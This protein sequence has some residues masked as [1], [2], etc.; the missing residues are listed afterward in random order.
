MALTATASKSTREL[1]TRSLFMVNSISI[2]MPPQKKNILYCVKDKGSI[3]SLVKRICL[4]LKELLIQYLRTIIFCKCYDECSEMY[5]TFRSEIKDYSTYPPGTPNLA[6]YRIV[7]TY[8][9]CT[10]AAVKESILQSICMMDGKLCIVIA[11]IAFGMCLDC[12]DIREVIHWGPSS[13]IESYVQETGRVGRDS[14]LSHVTLF[15]ASAGPQMMSYVSKCRRQ[16][17]FSD[18]DEDSGYQAP[19]ELCQCCDICRLHC[20]CAF[21]SRN[22]CVISD[23]FIGLAFTN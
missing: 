8:T 1:I 5:H 11:T 18:F 16:L 22:M 9:R 6:K 12:P 2:Y 10:E 13:D 17:L 4:P 23:S 19:C 7:D 14:Y 20:K 3:E 21:C 15:Y